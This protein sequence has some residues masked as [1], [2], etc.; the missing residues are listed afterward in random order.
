MDK[1]KILIVNDDGVASVGIRRLATA[2][3]KYGEVW[4]VAP[5]GERSASSHSLTLNK[6]LDVF[7]VDWGIEGIH[8]YSCSGMPTDCFRLGSK[9]IMPEPPDIVFSGIN[10][11][12][13]A[14]PDNQYSGTVG[15]ALDAASC[16]YATIAFSEGFLIDPKQG[17]FNRIVTDKYL[18]QVL[19]ELLGEGAAEDPAKTH[20]EPGVVVNVN[21]PDCRVEECKGIKWNCGVYMGDT[22]VDRYEAVKELPGGGTRYEIRWV[23]RSH[24]DEGTDMHALMNGYISIGVVNNIS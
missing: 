13:N 12:Y 18:P 2:A 7:P 3:M 5:D 6:P 16:G 23:D 9:Y 14:G 22:F 24:A 4:V 15:A 11:G 10:N 20:V 21:F 1:K 19:E 17:G 8:V